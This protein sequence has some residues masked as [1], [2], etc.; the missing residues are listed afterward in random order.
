ML[1]IDCGECNGLLLFDEFFTRNEY[2]KDADYIV[3]DA[4]EIVDSAVQQYLMYKCSRC[5]KLYKF[6]YMEWEKKARTK[7]A[8]EIMIARKLKV[9]REVVDPANVDPD[10]GLEWCGKCDGIDNEGNCFTDIIKV[11]TIIQ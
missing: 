4:G 9:F 11:C 3:D 7:I 2:L 6:T 5:N 1:G 10:N 8:K